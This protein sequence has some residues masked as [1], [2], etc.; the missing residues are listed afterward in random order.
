MIDTITQLMMHVGNEAA[1]RVAY[2]QSLDFTFD[3]VPYGLDLVTINNWFTHNAPPQFV[4]R[5][6][7]KG[8]YRVGLYLNPDS[9]IDVIISE[10]RS[11]AD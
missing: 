2:G 1:S 5:N 10:E 4:H 9:T 3:P 7:Q 11:Y 6:T 8:N